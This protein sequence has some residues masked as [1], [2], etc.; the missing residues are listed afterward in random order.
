M[1]GKRSTDTFPA[2]NEWVV[3]YEKIAF[4]SIISIGSWDEIVFNA[5]MLA[6]VGY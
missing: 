5:L 3:S 4:F 2:W 6:W 1:A